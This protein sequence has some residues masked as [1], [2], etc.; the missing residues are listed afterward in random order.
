[1]GDGV[2]VFKFVEM[3]WFDL[4]VLDVMFL[5]MD[6]FVVIWWLCD[7]GCWMFVVFL[8]VCDDIYD[9]VIGLIVGGDDYVTKLFSFEE[10][11]LVII[12]MY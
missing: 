3:V 12:A 5:D 9:K 1:V 10:V 8:I 11:R 4:L 7:F 2:I 6:G